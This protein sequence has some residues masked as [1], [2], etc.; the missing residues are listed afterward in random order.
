[1]ILISAKKK[2]GFRRCGVLHSFE[3]TEH[4]DGVFTAEQLA[5]LQ[6]EPMLSVS[7]V[8]AEEPK[9]PKAEK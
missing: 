2:D 9:K 8:L 4:D 3:A 7:V 6:A 5:I 1:M